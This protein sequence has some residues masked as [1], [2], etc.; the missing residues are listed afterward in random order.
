MD[1]TKK[2]RVD[3]GSVRVVT[4]TRRNNTRIDASGVGV[5]KVEVHSFNRLASTNV[6]ELEL[7]MQ[8]YTLLTI[9]NILA[10]VL[11]GDIIRPVR[12]L[13]SQDARSVGAEEGGCAGRGGVPKAGLVVVDNFERLKGSK[14]TLETSLVW[15]CKWMLVLYLQEDVSVTH[16]MEGPS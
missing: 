6:D 14:V 7:Q 5:P 12:D 11:A 4:I 13:R 3:V 9:G 10:N 16:W 8:W 2:S 15:L 1:T